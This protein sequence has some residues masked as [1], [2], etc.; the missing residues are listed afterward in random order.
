MSKDKLFFNLLIQI[1]LRWA[2][3]LDIKMIQIFVS[4]LV[5]FLH[6]LEFKIV[7]GE[8][9]PQPAPVRENRGVS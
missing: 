1:L 5:C 8:A 3:G 7:S 6:R 4:W 2:S 9:L